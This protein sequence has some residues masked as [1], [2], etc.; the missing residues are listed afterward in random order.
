MLHSPKCLLHLLSKGMQHR[1]LRHVISDN[2]PFMKYF[3]TRRSFHLN[4]ILHCP[5]HDPES[6]TSLLQQTEI[7]NSLSVS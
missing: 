7:D 5:F 3:A 2:K 4:L 1:N 6:D